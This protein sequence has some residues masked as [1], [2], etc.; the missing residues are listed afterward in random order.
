MIIHEIHTSLHLDG[1]LHHT[2]A[3]WVAVLMQLSGELGCSRGSSKQRMLTA[4]S[5]SSA[6]F[7][8]LCLFRDL[9]VSCFLG[10]L[11]NCAWDLLPYHTQSSII[12]LIVDFKSSLIILN[13]KHFSVSCADSVSA[14]NCFWERFGR[15][16]HCAHK[17][18]GPTFFKMGTR[19]GPNF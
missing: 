2:A 6:P 17:P 7:M 18:R 12:D 3:H 4:V 8:I 9:S 14:D 10:L 16:L 15:L 13:V 5:A 11:S 19:W 1:G